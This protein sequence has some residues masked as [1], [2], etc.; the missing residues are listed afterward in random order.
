MHARN[1]MHPTTRGGDRLS[2]LDGIQSDRLDQAEPE[3]GTLRQGLDDL[4]NQLE[5]LMVQ[6]REYGAKIIERDR[7][8]GQV[9]E[10]DLLL[11]RKMLDDL[12]QTV[13]EN[14]GDLAFEEA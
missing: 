8:S 12:V 4:L 10:Y 1:R 14:S 7:K 3:G 13:W 11:P 6:I 5:N 2:Y 9:V